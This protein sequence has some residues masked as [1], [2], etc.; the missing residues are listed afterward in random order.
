MIDINPNGK[1]MI[2]SVDGGGLRGMISIAMLAELEKKTGKT[3]SELFDMVAGT[4]T[5]AVIAAGIGLGLSAQE[6]LQE[7]YRTRLPDAFR[8]QPSGIGL[9]LRYALGGFRSLYTLDAFVQMIGPF[10][11]GKKVGDFTKPIVF[12]T[13]RDVRTANTYFIVSKGPGAASFADWPVTGAVAASG[14]APIFFP[15]VLGNLIDGG[16]GMHGNPCLAATVEAMEYISRED[17]N[18]RDGNV[19]HMS[20]GT[21]FLPVT[22]DEGA[23]GRFGIIGWLKYLIEEVLADT[24]VNQVQATRTIYRDRVDLRRYNPYLLSESVSEKLGISLQNRPKPESVSTGLSVLDQP[25]MEL[26]EEIGRVYAD[27]VD[28]T[29]P[30][31]VPWIET[32]GID[33][34]E[35]RDGGHPLPKIRGS[36]WKGTMFE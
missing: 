23:G 20:L 10:A 5:G 22:F 11:P 15:P 13:T 24:T 16:V 19:I 21:G 18:F 35:G 28:W 9:Y 17:A 31:Y 1:K 4:S 6:L 8:A 32:D 36:A 14:A 7:I 29:A 3:C 30:N 34:G 33:K 26:M 27:K 12:M 25:M 2:L